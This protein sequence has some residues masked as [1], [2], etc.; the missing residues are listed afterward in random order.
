MPDKDI[1][2]KSAVI[3]PAN[4]HKFKFVTDVVDNPVSKPRPSSY[5]PKPEK[6]IRKM[7][8][9]NVLTKH[10]IPNKLNRNVDVCIASSS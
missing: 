1:I 3:S 4:T 8:L 5:K 2:H 6:R 9:L 10:I 7:Q